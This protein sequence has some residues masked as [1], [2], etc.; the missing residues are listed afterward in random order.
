MGRLSPHPYNS[1]SLR[2]RALGAELSAVWRIQE[3]TPRCI[4]GAVSFLPKRPIRGVM[5]AGDWV[6]CPDQTFQYFYRLATSSPM[7]Y[8][9]CEM[10]FPYRHWRSTGGRGAPGSHGWSP[11][12]L[13]PDTLRLSSM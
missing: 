1:K 3:G 5:F 12:Y 11:R 4:P 8:P 6:T 2:C 7:S 9:K 10:E 13:R